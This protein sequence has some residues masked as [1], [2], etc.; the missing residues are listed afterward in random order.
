MRVS[1]AIGA[2]KKPKIRISAGKRKRGN[3]SAFCSMIEA[4]AV[5]TVVDLAGFI[6]PGNFSRRR[7]LMGGFRQF[8]RGIYYFAMVTVLHE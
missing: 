6:R 3:R 2:L 7:A 1:R 5:E 8:G 4:A